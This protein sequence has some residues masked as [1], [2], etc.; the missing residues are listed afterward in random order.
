MQA[1]GR[2]VEDLAGAVGFLRGALELKADLTFKNVADDEARVTVR[3]G[4]SACRIIY[5]GY[6]DRPVIERDWR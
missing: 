5:F 4:I 1:V 6:S 3:P 2:L